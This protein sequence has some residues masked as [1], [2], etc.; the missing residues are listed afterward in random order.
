[1]QMKNKIPPPPP[2]RVPRRTSELIEVSAMGRPFRFTKAN[3]VDWGSLWSLK[4]IAPF[5]SFKK[6][7]CWLVTGYFDVQ[8]VRQRD[9]LRMDDYLNYM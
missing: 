9:D 3:T 7:A 8:P 2:R 5:P 6:K 4:I 1:M